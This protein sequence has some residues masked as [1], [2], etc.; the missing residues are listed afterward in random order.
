M[1]IRGSRW[2]SV[3]CKELRIPELVTLLFSCREGKYSLIVSAIPS[4]PLHFIS[5]EDVIEMNLALK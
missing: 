2:G 4:T 3:D 1:E 5:H